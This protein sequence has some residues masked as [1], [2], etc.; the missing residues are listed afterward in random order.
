MVEYKIKDNVIKCIEADCLQVYFR[1]AFQVL[2][3]TKLWVNE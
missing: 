2:W 1:N 3:Q